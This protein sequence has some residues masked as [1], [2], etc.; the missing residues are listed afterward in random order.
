MI[1][2]RF[3]PSPTGNLHIGGAR[4]ALVNYLYAKHVGGVFGLRVEDSDRE[5]SKDEYTRD[6]L[7]GLAWL[8]M[9]WDEGPHFQKERM[10]IYREHAMKLLNEGKAYKC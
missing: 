6:I 5:R 1:K 7:E 3:A 10:D 4:T 9:Q 8:G 2:T